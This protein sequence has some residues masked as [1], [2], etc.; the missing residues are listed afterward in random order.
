MANKLKITWKKSTISTQKN[1][2]A[3]IK[4]MGLRRLNQSVVHEDTPQMRGMIHTV[5][6]LVDVEE[7]KE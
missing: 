6:F 1:H 7:V 2:R 3:T 4:A 5:Q